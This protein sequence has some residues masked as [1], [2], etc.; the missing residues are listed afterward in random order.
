MGMR[1]S[2]LVSLALVAAMAAEAT[3]DDAPTAATRS[4]LRELAD[5][6]RS[7]E[8]LIDEDRGLVVIDHAGGEADRPDVERRLCTPADR[9]GQ[10]VRLQRAMPSYLTPD[11]EGVVHACCRNRPGPPTCVLE[12]FM[13][14]VPT[15]TL[16]FAV[17]PVRGLRLR[18]VMAVDHLG[19]AAD[20]QRSEKRRIRRARARLAATTCAATRP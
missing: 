12:G 10:L 9:K 8:S 6:R 17:D 5:G 7:F 20:V 19:V 4:L 11:D 3:A 15:V 1:C 13:E 16:T 18:E 2:L 14:F